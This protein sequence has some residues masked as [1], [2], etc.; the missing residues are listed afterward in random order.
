MVK[1]LVR[2]AAVLFSVLDIVSRLPAA[3]RGRAPSCATPRLLRERKFCSNANRLGFESAFADIDYERRIP[4][5]S[6]LAEQYHAAAAAADR[7][8]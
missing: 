3:H 5:S 4:H 7:R 1:Q 2:V 6:I 8:L